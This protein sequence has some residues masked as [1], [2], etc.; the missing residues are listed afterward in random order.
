MESLVGLYSSTPQSGKSTVAKWLCEEHGYVCVPFA[1]TLKEAL[2]PVLVA[3]GHTTWEAKQL[4]TT[5]KHTYLPDLRLSVRQL[6]QTL[7]TEWGRQC[8]HPD[9]WL[10]CWKQRIKLYN[11]VVVDDVRFPNEADLV[12]KLGGS[13]WLI[14]RPHSGELAKHSSEGSLDTYPYFDRMIKNYGNLEELGLKLQQLT[15]P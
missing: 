10:M 9:L 6:L 15:L 3:L 8:V 12:K 4:V 13:M 11:K 7:G 14:D 5:D 2:I 1:E